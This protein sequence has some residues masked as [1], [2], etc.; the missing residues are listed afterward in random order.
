MSSTRRVVAGTASALSLALALGACATAGPEGG[1]VDA[2][3]RTDA[4][5][6]GP[7]VDAKV[8]APTT[9]GPPI[10][11]PTI[12][13][14]P[15][16]APTPI[17]AAPTIDAAC[18]PVTMQLLVNPSFD[19]NPVGTGWIET[20]IDPTYPLITSDD[21]VTEHTAPYKAWMGGF[22]S[23]DDELYQQVLIPAG[24]TRLVLRGQYDVRTDEFINGTYDHAAVALTTPTNV[25]LETALAT[26]DDHATTA[27]TS[28]QKIF[29]QTYAGQ[30]VRVRVRSDNDSSDATSFF[31]DTFV[32][33]A[34]VCP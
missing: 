19:L 27:W 33:E 13:G 1:D 11:G 5:V 30:S 29:S 17:D 8:D 20:P 25:V 12:D 15:I 9:D 34:T 26:D 22:L 7:Q 2:S 10:D 31:F 21:G 24:T 3:R 23:G 16:D 6:D 4:R 18:T 28:F 32:L 14:P